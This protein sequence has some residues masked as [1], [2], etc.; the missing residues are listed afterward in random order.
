LNSNGI[1]ESLIRTIVQRFTELNKEIEADRSLRRDSVIGHSYFCQ[2]FNTLLDIGENVWYRDI[3]E[4]EIA[5]LLQEYWGDGDKAERQT[6]KLL[7]P[8][9]E[10]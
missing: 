3:I 10:L 6:A 5:P 8:T 2:G 9:R 1:S 4:T 7:I